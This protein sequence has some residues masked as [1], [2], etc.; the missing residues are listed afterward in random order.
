[1]F[2]AQNSI[3]DLVDPALAR[4]ELPAKY[5]FLRESCA[6]QRFYAG[7]I[8][9]V[10]DRLHS[11]ETDSLEGK[12][13]S[14]RNCLGCETHSPHIP[15]SDEVADVAVPVNLVDGTQ[16]NVTDV[17]RAVILNYRKEVINWTLAHSADE[18]LNR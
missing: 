10:H 6:L 12:P 7:R 5:A 1:M 13:G 11:V 2:R 9:L 17:T 8:T 4:P 3:R 14:E 18:L 16:L 15:L